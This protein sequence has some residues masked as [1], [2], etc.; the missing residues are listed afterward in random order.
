MLQKLSDEY[1]VEIIILSQSGCG[2]A[3]LLK[4]V[5]TSNSGCAKVIEKNLST[6][7]FSSSSGDI[8]FLASLRMNRLGDQWVS[9]TNEMVN[10]AQFGEKALSDRK[11]ALHETV[12]LIKRLEKLQLHI[13][14]DAPKPIFKSPPFRCADW[15]NDSNPICLPGLTLKRDFLLEHRKAVMNSLSL[16]GNEFPKLIIWDPFPILCGSDICSSFDNK[17]PLFFDGDHLSGYGNMVVYEDFKRFI[18]AAANLGT[19]NQGTQ[20]LPKSSALGENDSFK[21]N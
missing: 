19:L 2:A 11:A 15:F 5:L 9:F 12:E 13:V 16:L 4:S 10:D 20:T 6:V 3:N 21:L 1:G 7:E 17:K 18:E 14:I 8:L